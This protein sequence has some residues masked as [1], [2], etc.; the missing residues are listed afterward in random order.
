[1]KEVSHPVAITNAVVHHL[2]HH[3]HLLQEVPEMVVVDIL[4]ALAPV[5]VAVDSVA[6][7]RK[8]AGSFR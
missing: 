5:V 4:N 3:R 2:R 8:N 6:M 1:V 7:Q